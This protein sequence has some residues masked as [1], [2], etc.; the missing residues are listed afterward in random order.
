MKMHI[1]IIAYAT[2]VFIL[3]TLVQFTL[4][5]SYW[6]NAALKIIFLLLIPALMMKKQGYSPLKR[7]SFSDV[8]TPLMLAIIC[9]VG[10]NLGYA[11]LSGFIDE[12]LIISS[13]EFGV[14][15]LLKIIFMLLYTLC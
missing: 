3:F 9:I 4:S 13:L 11:V 14:N 12:S 6:T 10:V 7:V 2:A 8:K 1:K 15:V 5:P